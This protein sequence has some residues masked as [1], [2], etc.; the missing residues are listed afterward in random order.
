MNSTNFVI[1]KIENLVAKI[2]NLQVRY[3]YDDF[4][5]S[6][7]VEVLP[8]ASYK[9]DESYITLEQEF[10][11]EFI[12]LF[13][14]ECLTFLSEGSLYEIEN[15]IYIKNGATSIH[16][17]IKNK[18][19]NIKAKHFVRKINNIFGKSSANFDKFQKVEHGYN[20]FALAA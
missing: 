9:E 17:F 19:V 11:N 1:Q 13:P 16:Y 3:E 6:H 4:D 12:K 8:L 5:N 2:P 14:R 18:N 15:P 10:R 7:Y 20:S